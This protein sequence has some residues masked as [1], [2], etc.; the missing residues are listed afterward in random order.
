MALKC[1]TDGASI[2][3]SADNGE[4]W[5]EYTDKLKLT[6]LP[7]T[8]FV[9][10]TKEGYEDSSIVTLNYTERTN[11]KYNLYFGQLHSHTNYSDGSGSCEDAYQHA[12]AV[13][14]LD[15]LAVTDHS[16]SFDNADAASIADGSV[17]SEWAEGHALA[18]KYTTKDFISIFGYEMTWSNGLGHVNTFNTDGFQIVYR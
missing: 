16:N 5:E 3:V 11:E 17:S 18:D 9:K 7:K 15:F 12:S 13:D 1:D 2:F 4:T 8:Y 6:E 10:A 14:N